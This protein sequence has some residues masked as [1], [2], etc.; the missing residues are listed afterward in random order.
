M[1]RRSNAQGYSCYQLGMRV[2]PT[3]VY[4][5]CYLWKVLPA[6][7]GFR[8][9]RP[10]QTQMNHRDFYAQVEAL[11]TALEEERR[12]G[13]AKDARHKLTVQRLQRHVTQLQV[14]LQHLHSR[15]TCIVDSVTRSCNE[16][17]TEDHA[18]ATVHIPTSMCQS[19]RLCSGEG[20]RIGRR[21]KVA[22]KACCQCCPAADEDRAASQQLARGVSEAS[23][24]GAAS[25]WPLAVQ[26]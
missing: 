17:S 23:A 13:R 5:Q 16:S 10:P 2:S 3:L 15:H 24:S 20:G 26:D 11:L 7:P 14:H 21:G 12:L 9:A 18:Q 22:C 19:S 4:S 6:C 25:S 1:H 8:K